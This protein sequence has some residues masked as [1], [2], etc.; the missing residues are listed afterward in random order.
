MHIEGSAAVDAMSSV[1]VLASS[2]VHIFADMAVKP[3]ENA[4]FENAQIEVPVETLARG[5]SQNAMTH[6]H[7]FTRHAAAAAADLEGFAHSA[8]A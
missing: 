1:V 2:P 4:M 5:A 3:K 8:A 6:Q 7:C